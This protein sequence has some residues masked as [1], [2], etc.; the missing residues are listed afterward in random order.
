MNKA[1]IDHT[2]KALYEINGVINRQQESLFEYHDIGAGGD[3]SS[4]FDL[5][6]ER[7]F[8]KYLHHFGVIDSEESGL[9]GRGESRIIL[10]PIDGSDNIHSL[11]PYYGASI[12]LQ[13]DNTTV[14][15][16]VCNFAT[17][18][19]FVRDGNYLYRTRLDDFTCKTEVV[20]HSHSKI[21]LFEKSQ[22][23]LDF[24]KILMNNGLKYR[25][26]GAIA[27][28]LSYAHYVDYVLF[29][30]T[31][32]NYDIEAGLFLCKD[33]HCFIDESIVLVSKQ[34]D[35]FEKI[36]ALFANFKGSK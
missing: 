19:C 12:A 1:F 36:S 23:H 17:K 33:L 22:E 5:E 15:A 7:I 24:A 14:A 9:M 10:D 31:I 27:L 21:G 35:T 30:G 11:F 4:G 34:R 29:L 32:R 13:R 3:Q 28:S 18:I 8:F 6:A 20:V 26:P 25:S 2:F 16:V